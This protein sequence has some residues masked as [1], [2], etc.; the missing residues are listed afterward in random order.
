MNTIH[1]H[2]RSGHG[3][4]A[5][6][7]LGVMLLSACATDDPKSS[8]TD[9]PVNITFDETHCPTAVDPNN[10]NVDKASNQRLAWQ[11]VDAAGESINE[12]FTIYFDPFKG[13]PLKAN[14]KGFRKSPKFDPD[15]PVNVEYKYTVVGER[16]P[17][18]PLDP[19]FLLN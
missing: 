16:C 14:S 19:R 11:A 3:L 4:P 2:F 7:M 17:E 10:P 18:K 9:I 1:Q 12:G 13:G 8:R 5:A 6:L 15:T